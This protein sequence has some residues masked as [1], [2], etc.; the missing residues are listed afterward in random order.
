MYRVSAAADL[1]VTLSENPYTF[2]TSTPESRSRPA[3]SAHRAVQC[4]VPMSRVAYGTDSADGRNEEMS[5]SVLGG[6]G[7]Y[8]IKAS[9]GSKSI[10][11]TTSS[12]R[13][14]K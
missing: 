13:S 14:W 6:G 9:G 11:G 2:S 1:Q 4:P 10:S 7:E 12:T 5:Y 8:Y 3:R